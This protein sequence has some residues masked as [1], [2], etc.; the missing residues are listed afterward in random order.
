MEDNQ[1]IHSPAQ[2]PVD[3]GFM[4]V[5]QKL[6]SSFALIGYEPHSWLE[7]I[8]KDPPG[9][10]FS[11][12]VH[13]MSLGRTWRS[14]RKKFSISLNRPSSATVEDVLEEGGLVVAESFWLPRPMTLPPP[15][16][17]NAPPSPPVHGPNWEEEGNSGAW[18]AWSCDSPPL[19]VVLLGPKVAR[20]VCPPSV[21]P[22]GRQ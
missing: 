4:P 3:S 10:H 17:M 18:L 16:T 11:F 22:P 7:H 5:K 20:L 19:L 9:I 2:S 13:P 6:N 21:L 8:R 15:S 12:E 14:I 1:G